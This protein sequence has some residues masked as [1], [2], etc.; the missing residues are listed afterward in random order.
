[1]IFYF[2]D[3]FRTRDYPIPSPE[4]EIHRADRST[5]QPRLLILLFNINWKRTNSTIKRSWHCVTK[6]YPG[7]CFPTVK[8]I[9]KNEMFFR[10]VHFSLNTETFHQ[11]L[12]WVQWL[13]WNKCVQ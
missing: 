5:T 3:D 1:M 6:K 10:A 4:V 12:Y 11:Q 9:Q 13:Q 2:H 8:W 7:Q